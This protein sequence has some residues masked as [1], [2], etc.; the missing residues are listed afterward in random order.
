MARLSKGVEVEMY[1]GTSQGKIVGLSDR[2]TQDLN[3]FVREPD[4]RNVEYTTA[5][6]SCYDRLL[7][8]LVRPRQNLRQYLQKIGNYTIIPG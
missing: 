6:L 1:T 4:N 5:P 8:A 2:I 3:G 7:C